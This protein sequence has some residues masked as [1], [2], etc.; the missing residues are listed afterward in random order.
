MTRT[1]GLIVRDLT[2]TRNDGGTLVGPL[3]FE[4]ESGGRLGII[5]ESGSGKSLTAMAIIGLLADGLGAAGSIE[6][7]GQQV[8]GASDRVMN[9]VRGRDVA[10]V[11]QE[12]LTALD[13][14]MKI[15][16]QL[17]EPLRRRALADGQRLS[18]TSVAALVRERLTEV[19]LA[20]P[21][22][23]ARAFPH[24]ISGGQRQRAA[25]AI[26][27]AGRPRLLIADEP[28]TALDVTV[29]SEILD[30]LDRLVDDHGMSLLFVSHDLA[31]VARIAP[32]VVVLEH[33]KAVETGQL[34]DLLARPQHPYTRELVDSARELDRALDTVLGGSAR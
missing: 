17:A 28:T 11:F 1:A 9:G 8:V 16:N 2:I 19:S 32:R 18:R 20:E 12:P 13:P 24:E 29:Q 33:G 5:G 7:D 27:I 30:L 31:V 6:L 3:S 21:D 4:L 25:L 10:V 22:R 14:L 26:A 23:I 15:G 34:S